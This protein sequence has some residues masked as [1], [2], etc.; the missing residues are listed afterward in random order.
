M[1]RSFEVAEEVDEEVIWVGGT[2]VF[3]LQGI[4]MV[5]VRMG[6]FMMSFCGMAVGKDNNF[7]DTEDG[8]G[9]GDVAA[10][11]G[12]KLMGLC[13]GAELA[14]PSLGSEGN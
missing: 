7:V 5:H 6:A 3:V 8:E 10:Q 2:C 9:A 1:W 13:A 12:S 4:W 14:E 11:G